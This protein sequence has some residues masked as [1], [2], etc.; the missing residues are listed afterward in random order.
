MPSHFKVL[1]LNLNDTV[2]YRT[3]GGKKWKK[4]TILLSSLIYRIIINAI[5]NFGFYITGVRYIAAGYRY[6]SDYRVYF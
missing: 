6:F 3:V 2:V 4:D 1:F 5:L